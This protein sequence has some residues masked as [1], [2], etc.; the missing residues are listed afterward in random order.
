MMAHRL[1]Q[2]RTRHS[3]GVA[4][5]TV[6]MILFFVMALV[7][8]YTNRNLV[9]EQRISANSYRSARA[10]DASEAAIDWSLSMLN[11]GRIGT[12]CAGSND[13]VNDKDFRSNY[14]RL[15]D[16]DVA[17]NAGRYEM[18]WTG[19]ASKRMFP[20]CI[21]R[22]GVLSCICP[23]LASRTPSM[24]VPTDGIGTAFNVLLRTPTNALQP[25]TL[26]IDALGCASIGTGA[27][28]CYNQSSQFEVVSDAKSG[29]RAGIGLVQALPV[30][31][32]STLTVG[33]DVNG[34]GALVVTNSGTAGSNGKTAVVAGGSITAPLVQ[35]GVNLAL[36]ATS[37]RLVAAPNDVAPFGNWFKSRFGV[38]MATFKNQP[39]VVSIDCAA[40]CNSTH[41]AAVQVRFPRNP[42]WVEGN[43]TISAPGTLGSNAGNITAWEPLLLVVN[44]TLTV[45]A[46][47]SMVGF[48]HATNI[49]W[50]A[51]GA[52][53][54]GAMM[55]PGDFTATT[56]GTLSYNAKMLEV[57]R[58][59][60]G[61]FVRVPGSW[62]QLNTIS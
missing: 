8:A 40:G 39:A 59:Y 21:S 9:F 62:K 56:A 12:S 13:T 57:I 46:N 24:V 6:V 55:T 17:N 47:V 22:N 36:D 15:A 34:S 61:S 7:A 48:I 25:G 31:P 60:Y 27:G 2:A 52:S 3:R 41:L 42:I 35:P 5:L 33:K 18:V 28:A 14:L 58:L 16:I 11:G 37:S 26:N 29:V 54:E 45:A 51:A 53:L 50:S 32:E 10:L 19:D 44:G 49:V 43:L 30:V 1:P 20:A 38:D 23:T 4:A